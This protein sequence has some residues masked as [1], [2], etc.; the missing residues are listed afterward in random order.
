MEDMTKNF[1]GISNITKIPD[2]M[3]VVDPKK[4]HIAVTES[5]KMNIPVISLLNTDCNLKQITYPIVGNDASISSI[6]F[7]LSLIKKAYD[8]GAKGI[9]TK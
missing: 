6:N 2:V 1:Q 3:I 8:D 5:R 4:E 7:F 9:E